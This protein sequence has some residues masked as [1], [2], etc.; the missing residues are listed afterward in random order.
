[1][2]KNCKTSFNSYDADA[3]A[4]MPHIVQESLPCYV[5]HRCAI[6]KKY[7]DY[8]RTAAPQGLAF[9]SMARTADTQAGPFFFELN[10]ILF[11]CLSLHSIYKVE[12]SSSS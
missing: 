4:K 8:I 12:L 6:D 9:E 10:L 1:M 5:T 2:C 7:M 3:V 11:L